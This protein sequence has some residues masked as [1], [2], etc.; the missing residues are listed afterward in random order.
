MTSYGRPTTAARKGTNK[1]IANFLDQTKGRTYNRQDSGL[2]RDSGD[3]SG[4]TG[5]GFTKGKAP[6]G[7]AMDHLGEL[8]KP[9]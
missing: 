6:G 5:F 2:T 9:T 4:R 1:D 3:M 8:S 7:A